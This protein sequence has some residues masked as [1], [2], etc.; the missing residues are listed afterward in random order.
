MLFPLTPPAFSSLPFS[1][2]CSLLSSLSPRRLL[3]ALWRICPNYLSYWQL[4]VNKPRKCVAF[5][6]SS[7]LTPFLPHYLNAISSHF[8]PFPFFFNPTHPHL[9]FFLLALNPRPPLVVFTYF[10]LSFSTL[11]VRQQNYGEAWEV[12]MVLSTGENEFCYRLCGR[13]SMQGS[14]P[15]TKCHLA[16]GLSE[17]EIA[18][19]HPL[20]C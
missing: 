9:I 12:F 10:C 7:L 4:R 3:Q 13:Y 14:R 16:W 6:V 17:L 8:T 2:F 19:F 1:L 15:L 5:S 20:S 18:A 11:S